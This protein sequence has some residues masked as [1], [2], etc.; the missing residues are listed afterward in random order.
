MNTQEKI[1]ELGLDHGDFSRVI[2]QRIN[3]ALSLEEKLDKA[4]QEVETDDTEQNR[5]RL[6]DVEVYLE[7]FKEDFFLQLTNLK[8]KIEKENLEIAKK[9]EKESDNTGAFLLGALILVGTLGA[10]N[11]MNKK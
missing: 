2:M 4:R 11:V 8:K 10:V 3:T 7:E 5:S 6:D 1:K 9:D